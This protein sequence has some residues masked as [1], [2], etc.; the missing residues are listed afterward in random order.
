MPK[1]KKQKYPHSSSR[2]KVNQQK[3]IVLDE[4][5]ILYKYMPYEAFEKTIENWNM[6]LT[7]A[8]EAN[9]PFEFMAQCEDENR[10]TRQYIITAQDRV[11]GLL[12]F[13]RHMSSAA[14]WGHYADSH[15]GVCLAFGF[16]A[17]TTYIPCSSEEKLPCYIVKNSKIKH[18][19]VPVKYASE[20][21][22]YF[23]QNI[24]PYTFGTMVRQLVT[25]DQSWENEQECRIM[26]DIAEADYFKNGMAFTSFPMQYLRGVILG[27]RCGY[28]AEYVNKWLIQFSKTHL[29]DNNHL[30][31]FGNFF[32]SQGTYHWKKFKIDGRPWEDNM[33]GSDQ[34]MKNIALT[35]ANVKNVEELPTLDAQTGKTSNLAH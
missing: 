6:K 16:P 28:G 1:R 5:L 32:V 13:S 24:T 12:C 4:E 29:R 9:D 35:I 34:L 30:Q 26:I 18:I 27:A 10:D 31:Q 23:Q 25:K 20:R 8:H 17:E 14:M 3:I 22:P 2:S 33:F 19:I 11:P 7:L 21:A 15:K